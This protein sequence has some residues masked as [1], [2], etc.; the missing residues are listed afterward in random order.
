MVDDLRMGP[1]DFQ[2]PVPE[3]VQPDISWESIENLSDEPHGA[4]TIG[5][6]VE[7]G[8]QTEIEQIGAL[9]GNAESRTNQT[10]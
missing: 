5:P 4:L 6:P 7:I 9:F 10:P 3:Q 1:G 8:E 2:T